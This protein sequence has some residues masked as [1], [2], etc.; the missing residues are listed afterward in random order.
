MMTND[1]HRIIGIGTKNTKMIQCTRWSELTASLKFHAELAQ[2]AQA[3]TEFRLLNNCEP[4]M[5]GL[6]TDIEGEAL[7]TALTVS[8]FSV[9]FSCSI[10]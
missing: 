9:V 8:K 7:Q 4:I 3:P 6:A 10:F 5:V 2:A 1:G